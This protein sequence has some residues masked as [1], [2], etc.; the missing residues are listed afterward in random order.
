MRIVLN[1]K[2]VL[3]IPG[4]AIPVNN[5]QR[6]AKK[7]AVDIHHHHHPKDKEHVHKTSSENH[8]K[9]HK[10]DDHHEHVHD[11]NCKHEHKEEHKKLEEIN[12]QLKNFAKLLGNVSLLEVVTGAGAVAVTKGGADWMSWTADSLIECLEN[13]VLGAESIKKYIPKPLLRF[14]TQ[15]SRPG[16]SHAGH[17]HG[18]DEPCDDDT[19]EHELKEKFVSFMSLIGSSAA[20]IYSLVEPF[21][22]K[23]ETPKREGFFKPV[24]ELI[25]P[26]FT[27]GLM[28]LSGL[29]KA[30]VGKVAQNNAALVHRVQDY[31]CGFSSIILAGASQFKKISPGVSKFIEV[32]LGA[33]FAIKSLQNALMG[34]GYVVNLER[35]GKL[36]ATGDLKSLLYVHEEGKEK[37][38]LSSFETHPYATRIYDLVAKGLNNTFNL[39]L[40]LLST[41][42]KKAFS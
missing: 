27:A 22:V 36:I 20:L 9:L 29:V 33:G 12:A 26:S 14:I 31:I 28:M 16:T 8:E 11:E 19:G 5:I 42:A 13:Y 21:K 37:Y 38:E 23:R 40:P 3:S 15:I 2:R 35:I 7:P 30:R 39:K 24:F 10:Q 25:L 32:T 18:L 34:L 41:E 4:L 6:P 1:K 17:N